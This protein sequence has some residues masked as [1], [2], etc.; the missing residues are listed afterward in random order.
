MTKSLACQ[1]RAHDKRP[2]RHPRQG[3]LTPS[4]AAGGLTHARETIPQSKT[5]RHR[6]L[7]SARTTMISIV[8]FIYNSDIANAHHAL[9][10]HLKIK[11][12][13]GK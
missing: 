3:R 5:T 7:T 9:K 12:T 4:P 6:P 10:A 8:T 11:V 13:G 2:S 1:A